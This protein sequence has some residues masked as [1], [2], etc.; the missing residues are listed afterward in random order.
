MKNGAFPKTGARSL[1]Y[2][3]INCKAADVAAAAVST[4]GRPILLNFHV[5]R[6][7]SHRR[8]CR[9]PQ[10]YLRQE[11]KIESSLFVADSEWPTSARACASPLRLFASVAGDYLAR[12]CADAVA[13]TLSAVNGTRR[14]KERD[15]LERGRA[16]ERAKKKSFRS[17]IRPAI[18]CLFNSS[19]RGAL[20]SVRTDA[21]LANSSGPQL[22]ARNKKNGWPGG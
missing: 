11:Q 10:D 20:R 18:A 12:A 17:F 3:T 4:V 19:H 16:G 7:A 1:S 21:C 8:R 22:G 6:V 9:R 5:P 13:V 2:E 15:N 14:R